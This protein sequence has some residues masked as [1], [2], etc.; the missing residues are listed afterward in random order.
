MLTA[1][2]DNIEHIFINYY[3]DFSAYI[4]NIVQTIASKQLQISNM[5]K[6]KKWH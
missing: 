2:F 1:Q 4:I 5:Q 6:R 3:M